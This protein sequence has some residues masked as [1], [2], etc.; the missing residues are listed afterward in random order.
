MLLHIKEWFHQS[1]KSTIISLRL[2]EKRDQSKFRELMC[3]GSKTRPRFEAPSESADRMIWCEWQYS[4]LYFWLVHINSVAVGKG[5]ATDEIT[6]RSGDA[7]LIQEFEERPHKPARSCFAEG[8][9]G[10]G[11]RSHWFGS[12]AGGWRPGE[13]GRARYL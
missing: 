8:E 13:P 11:A 12:P 9:R 6:K 2:K 10:G 7:I 5:V 3:F 1:I 4:V